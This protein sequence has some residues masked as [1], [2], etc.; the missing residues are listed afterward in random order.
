MKNEILAQDRHV[1]LKCSSGNQSI[2]RITV[3]PIQFRH[4]NPKFK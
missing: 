4:G 2:C 3:S 1:V